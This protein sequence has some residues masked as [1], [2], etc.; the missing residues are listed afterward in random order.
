MS[1]EPA[2]ARTK[3]IP[4]RWVCA[5]FVL[6]LGIAAAVVWPRRASAE[7]TLPDGSTLTAVH[8]SF[9]QSPARYFPRKIDQVIWGWVPHHWSFG[10]GAPKRTGIK[11]W[12]GEAA[13]KRSWV[14]Y[15]HNNTNALTIFFLRSTNVSSGLLRITAIDSSSNLWGTTYPAWEYRAV[16]STHTNVGFSVVITHFPRTEKHVRLRLYGQSTDWTNW[17]DELLLRNPAYAK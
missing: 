5:A 2:P 3:R 10:V 4:A 8:A 12:L 15:N 16:T 1:G 7:L 13:A 11:A 6:A 9:G 14:G 17:H